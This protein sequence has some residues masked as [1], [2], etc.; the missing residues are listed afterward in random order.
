MRCAVH[1]QR[2]S[3][4]IL[5]GIILDLWIVTPKYPV[6]KIKPE[7]LIDQRGSV[8]SVNRSAVIVVAGSSSGCCAQSTGSL[9]FRKESDELASF[10]VE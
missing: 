2:K 6:C 7:T 8:V 3:E 9:C 4:V 10:I 1:G 5:L